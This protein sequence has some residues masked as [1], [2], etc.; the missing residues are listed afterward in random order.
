MLKVGDKIML[1]DSWITEEYQVVQA[2]ILNIWSVATKMTRNGNI[3]YQ[4]KEY[5]IQFPCGKID[6]YPL[7]ALKTD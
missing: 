7:L 4:N 5:D 3:L 1:R 2:K 6:T